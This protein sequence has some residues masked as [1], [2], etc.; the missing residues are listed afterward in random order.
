MEQFGVSIITGILF[1]LFVY[2][3]GMVLYSSSKTSLLRSFIAILICTILLVLNMYACKSLLTIFNT[4]ILIVIF[5]KIVFQKSFIQTL[6]GGLCIY[7]STVIV[8]LGFILFK[9]LSQGLM[10]ISQ[11]LTMEKLFFIVISYVIILSIFV[12]FQKYFRKAIKWFNSCLNKELVTITLVYFCLTLIFFIKM[13]FSI[14]RFIFVE[15][16]MVIMISIAVTFIFLNEESKKEKL[17]SKYD[18]IMNQA[19]YSEQLIEEYRVSLQQQREEF[20]IIDSLLKNNKRQAK[21]YVEGLI[22]ARESIISEWLKELRN[23]PSPSLKG[24]ISYKMLEMKNKMITTEIAI[25]SSISNVKDFDLRNSKE[26]Y[27]IV[28]FLLDRAIEECLDLNEK[29]ISIQMYQEKGKI[30][31]VIANTY[32]HSLTKIKKLENGPDNRVINR[33]LKHNSLYQLETRVFRNFLVQDLII[34]F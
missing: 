25:S 8:E 19:L 4:Y 16:I 11:F 15:D 5:H 18:R 22:T 7:I 23:I 1:I 12:L 17:F 29:M 10:G 24:L 21:K 32:K 14:C 20:M 34:S 13:S 3:G 28:G 31:L 33:V 30:H 6:I 27:M 9:V 26:L 2:F